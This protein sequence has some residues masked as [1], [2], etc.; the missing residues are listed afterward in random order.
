MRSRRRLPRCQAL[1]AAAPLSKGQTVAARANV[2]DEH[3]SVVGGGEG[4]MAIARWVRT[5]PI[6]A[7][8]A[9]D[10]CL[11]LFDGYCLTGIV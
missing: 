4:G 5:A 7:C 2:S 10:W 11:I 3:I 9:P 6:V 8:L 1:V